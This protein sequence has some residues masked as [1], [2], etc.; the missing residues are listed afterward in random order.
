[1]LFDCYETTGTRSISVMSCMI[2]IRNYHYAIY[3]ILLYPKS[4]ITAL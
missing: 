1:M 2:W 3:H 4:I